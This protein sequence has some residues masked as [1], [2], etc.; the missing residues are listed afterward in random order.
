MIGNQKLTF[1]RRVN[2]FYNGLAG[3]KKT[4]LAQPNSGGVYL[5]IEGGTVAG[6]VVVTGVY[7]GGTTETISTFDSDGVGFGSKLWTA[8]TQFDIT[9]FSGQ[10]I[11]I[12]PASSTKEIIG[13]DTTTTFN[14]MCN[15]YLM[16]ETQ[17][18]GAFDIPTGITHRTYREVVYDNRFELQEHDTTV[19][20]GKTFEVISIDERSE[21]MMAAFMIIKRL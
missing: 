3:T 20:N 12:Y 19:I 4:P 16:N 6:S 13:L 18:K 1:T 17:F 14:I 8:L 2:Y 5:R 9:G 11:T 21:D 15:H 7:S 10:T